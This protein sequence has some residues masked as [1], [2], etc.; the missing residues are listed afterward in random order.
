[1]TA[2]RAVVLALA[3]ALLSL[4]ASAQKPKPRA[5]LVEA[6]GDEEALSAFVA[7]LESD[8]SD[9]GKATLSDAR[10]AGISL[11]AVVAEPDGEA[12]RVLRAEWAAAGWIGISLAPCRVDVSRMTYRERSPEGYA[13]DRVVENVR[14]DCPATLRIVDSAT[15][16]EKKPLEVTGTANYRRSGPDDEESPQLEATRDAAEKAA[17]KLPAAL[18]R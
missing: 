9:R 3:G 2:A 12:A 4:P 5:V 10:L 11:G 15:G 8:L 7:R 14:V 1:M 17:K 16:K 13:Y 6:D 18:G